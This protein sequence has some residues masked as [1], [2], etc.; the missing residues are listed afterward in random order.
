MG[1]T[2][3]HSDRRWAAGWWSARPATSLVARRSRA[4]ASNEPVRKYVHA[5][6]PTTR[7]SSTPSDSWNLRAVMPSLMP[8][9]QAVAA[10]TSGWYKTLHGTEVVRPS[11]GTSG[12]ED[13]MP[14]E[15]RWTRL[16]S[17]LMRHHGGTAGVHGSGRS[18]L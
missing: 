2:I 15:D 13:P 12:G 10:R 3:T 5:P 11:R 16:V 8:S 6:S 7:Q 14:S 4:P 17:P 18:F 9:P 1:R